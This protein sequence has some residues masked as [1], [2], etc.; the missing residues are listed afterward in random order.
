MG[1]STWAVSFANWHS[2]TAN[3][4]ICDGEEDES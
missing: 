4:E 1:M 3:K 2:Y